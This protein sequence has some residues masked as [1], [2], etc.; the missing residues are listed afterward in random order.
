MITFLDGDQCELYDHDFDVIYK[1]RTVKTYVYETLKKC[2][3][4]GK[5]CK[6]QRYKYM[7]AIHECDGDEMY[8]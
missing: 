5:E 2:K 8:I 1:D 3:V 6:S 4:C 7:P